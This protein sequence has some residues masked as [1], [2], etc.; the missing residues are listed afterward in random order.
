MS[1]IENQK[2]S[3]VAM[4]LHWLMAILII[5]NLASAKLTEGL[6]RDIRGLLMYQHRALGVVLLALIL[7]RLYWRLTHKVPPL[8]AHTTPLSALAAHAAHWTL[9]AT[10]VILP[11]TGIMGE[12][13]RGRSL[14]LWVVNIASPFAG[15]AAMGKLFRQTH[16]L[17]GNVMIALVTIHILAALYHQFVKRDHLIARLMPSSAKV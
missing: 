7:W 3:G 5:F 12:L 9:Y 14:G 10:M 11:V 6:S 1:D 16:G 17:I 15:D 8:P 13:T 4:A 2:Y